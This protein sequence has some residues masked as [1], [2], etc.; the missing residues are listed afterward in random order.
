MYLL[1]SHDNFWWLD[2]DFWHFIFLE[3]LFSGVIIFPCLVINR[4]FYLS[5]KPLIDYQNH[6][7]IKTSLTPDVSSLIEKLSGGEYWLNSRALDYSLSPPI[8]TFGLFFDF[9]LFLVDCSTNWTIF[10]GRQYKSSPTC[11]MLHASPTSMS[12]FFTTDCDET[13]YFRETLSKLH[14]DQI[15]WQY[16]QDFSRWF[17]A[18]LIRDC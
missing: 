14:T 1:S 3:I 5:R 16:I 8:K 9:G 12:P 18:V 2:T 4:W 15:L 17:L 6:K 13:V 10:D 7:K 11:R